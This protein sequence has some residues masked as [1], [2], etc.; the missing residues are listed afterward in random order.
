[1][2][3][4]W[5]SNYGDNLQNLWILSDLNGDDDVDAGDLAVIEGN[6]GMANPSWS[7]GDLDGDGDVDTD[8][9]DLAFAQYG[10]DLSVA[11]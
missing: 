11:S 6:Y 2:K 5:Q 10:L 3:R 9:Y 1:M 7:D 4:T 8:D